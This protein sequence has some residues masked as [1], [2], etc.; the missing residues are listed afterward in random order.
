MNK[1]ADRRSLVENSTVGGS[2]QPI[3][4][5]PSKYGRYLG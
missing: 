1:F 5:R 2:D 4:P 3:Q